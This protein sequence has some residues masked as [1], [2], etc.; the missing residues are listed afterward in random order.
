M[1]KTKL[2][3]LFH[4][5]SVNATADKTRQF[6]LVLSAVFTS[7]FPVSTSFVSILFPICNCS[8]SN[9]FRDYWK[10]GNWKLGRDKTKLSLSCLQLCS[11][12]RHGQDSLVL[13][14]LSA[15]TSYYSP[16][17][18]TGLQYRTVKNI[19][20]I[21]CGKSTIWKMDGNPTLLSNIPWLYNSELL[22]VWLVSYMDVPTSQWLSKLTTA[23]SFPVLHKYTDT[24][25][26]MYL[27]NST[28]VLRFFQLERLQLNWPQL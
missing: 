10:L 27:T 20:I 16:R 18:C 9:I 1:D 4:I 22:S 2:S 25:E 11:H 26:H 6:C 28:T 17:A 14:V 3:R 12:R 24:L 21:I 5:G 15:W 19:I 7:F 8:V 13:S 23:V